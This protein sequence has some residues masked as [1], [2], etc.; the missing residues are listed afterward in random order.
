MDAG[1]FEVVGFEERH[2]AEATEG[3]EEP[4]R[5][6]FDGVVVGG[7]GVVEVGAGE[8]DAL[9]GLDEVGLELCEGWRGGEGGVVFGEAD[10]LR[11]DA[12]EVGALLAVRGGGELVA[13]GGEGF[14]DVA[15]VGFEAVDDGDELGDEVGAAFQDVLFMKEC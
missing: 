13:E 14:L 4:V 12:G 5:E 7:S 10:D 1:A 6:D 11:G 9:F 15:F 3:G 2:A 8:G